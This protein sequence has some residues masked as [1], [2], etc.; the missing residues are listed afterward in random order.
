[1]IKARCIA[2]DEDTAAFFDAHITPYIWRKHL[3]FAA[4]ADIH[5]I[6]RQMNTRTGTAMAIGGHNIKLGRGGIREIEFYVQ[7]QQLVWG[8]R[9]PHL[10]TRPTLAT[11]A[12]LV[13]SELITVETAHILA[14]AYRYL[15]RVEHHLQMLNDQ[16]TH[17]L[18]DR[19]DELL[20]LSV[21][22]GYGSVAAFAEELLK[23]CTAVHSIYSRSM[24][25]T[26]PL[27]IDGNLV[28]TGVEAD[29][30]TLKTLE[31][32]GYKHPEGVSD[33]I[34]SWHRGSRRATRSKRA[35]QLLTELIPALLTELADTAS[36]D[37]AFFR[38]DD[39]LSKLPAGVQ[40]FSLFAARPELLDLLAHI[41]GS[42]PALADI[43]GNQ[44]HLLDTVLHGDFYDPLPSKEE[45][46]AELNDRLSL[47][48]DYEDIL[49]ILRSFKNERQFQAGIQ[50]LRGLLRPSKIGY[51]L[52]DLADVTLSAVIKAASV[53]FTRT[54]GTIEGSR[55]GVVALGKLGSRELTFGSD[56]D[57]VL[58]YDGDDAAHSGG[59]QKSVD[60]RTYYNRLCS[61]IVNACTILTREGMLYEIDTRL[62]PS[63]G[64][65]PVATQLSSFDHY[66][67]SSAWIFEFMALTKARVITS[68]ADSLGTALNALIYRHLQ[69]PHE[70][71]ELAKEV[72]DMRSKIFSQHRTVN[73]WDIKHVRG[74]LIDLDFLAQYLVLR[75]AAGTPAIL[76]RNSYNILAAA[77]DAGHMNMAL[78][79]KLMAAH[80]FLTDMLS[81]LRLCSPNSRIE[82][83][84]PAG[85]KNLLVERFEAEDFETLQARLAE[86]EA[87]VLGEFERLVGV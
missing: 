47:A 11:L 75:H 51:F 7:T 79:D 9:F 13:E 15:R 32:M 31:S 87:F 83:S 45:L 3:D 80:R 46:Y 54:H 65:S 74:G 53:E 66:F 69:R 19:D 38:F 25:D 78:A 73:P 21:F 20:R 55:L 43:L 81:F 37:N 17:T 1:M 71:A 68:S 77:A 16:Q 36:P 63:G 84:T 62:R 39:F 14:D 57:L 4:I 70:P 26:P 22:L 60:L 50:M 59:G 67:S 10:R 18:P 85:L 72:A 40:I 23:H 28:F 27:S 76:Q 82:D 5:S 44:P 34:Q 33:I 8:G 64:D 24:D 29:P 49:S 61:R 12:G 52:S 6:K 41:L 35:R 58:I 86:T 48:N 56:L 42:A 30:E 2:G